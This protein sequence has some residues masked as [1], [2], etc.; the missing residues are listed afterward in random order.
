MACYLAYLIVLTLTLSLSLNQLIKYPLF[1]FVSIITANLI[2]IIIYRPYDDRVHNIG[3]ILNQSV[4]LVNLAWLISQEYIYLSR[5]V[6]E[7]IA[8]A[9]MGGIFLAFIWSLLR[10]IFELRKPKDG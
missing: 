4:V 8:F 3:L 7:V 5:V 6:D 10:I 9:L 2:F 1:V